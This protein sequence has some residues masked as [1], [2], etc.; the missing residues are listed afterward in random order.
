MPLPFRVTPQT[1]K[2][3]RDVCQKRL[4]SERDVLNGGRT[5]NFVEARWHVWCLLRERGY[6][7][8]KIAMIFG[9][10][11]ST[12]IHGVR[13]FLAKYPDQNLP[14]QLDQILSK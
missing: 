5:R 7:Y 10:D 1:R 13:K 14:E 4:V 12:V 2:I 11:H 6:S 9:M 3:V 8:K